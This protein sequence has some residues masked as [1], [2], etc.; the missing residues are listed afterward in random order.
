[1]ILSSKPAA[2]LFVLIASILFVSCGKN[3]STAAPANGGILTPHT[4]AESSANGGPMTSGGFD[5]SVLPLVN[6]GENYNILGLLDVNLNMDTSDEQVLIT[7]PLDDESAPLRLMIATTNPIRNQYDIVWDTPLSLRSLRGLTLRA[8]D[9]TGNGRMDII[10]TGFDDEGRHSTEVFGVPTKGEITD[11]RR[12][13]GQLVEGNIDI[14][15]TER[16]SQYW[17]GITSGDPFDIVVQMKDPDSDNPMD[18]VENLWKWDSRSFA[19]RQRS[20]SKIRAETLLE[21]R[22]AH[23]YSGGVNVFE[24]Y[25]EGAWYRESGDGTDINMIF[26]DRKSREMVFYDGSVQEVYSWGVSN[27]ATAQRLYTNMINAVIP[28]LSDRLIIIADSWDTIRIRWSASEEDY[29]TY[30]RFGEALQSVL[31]EGSSI[32]SLGVDMGLTGVWESPEGSEII[33][34]LP[35]IEWE[36]D[37]KIRSGTASIF[38]LDGVSVLQ[39]QFMKKNGAL[40]ET[41]NWVVEYEED[42]DETKVIRS[43][44]LTPAFLNVDGVVTGDDAWRRFEQIEILSAGD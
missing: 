10:I 9:V 37:G 40:E 2:A 12:I 23:V 25:L 15:S 13:F 31:G 11:Y 35:K 24:E 20:S 36:E 26:F 6:P 44:S 21:A 22:I 17:S 42:R 34:D 30:R 43:L 1:M 32:S 33:F 18:I 7:L 19:Y 5:D 14:I 3:D 28:S 4:E 8:N 29:T 39:V 38:V 27:R 16:T 41:V